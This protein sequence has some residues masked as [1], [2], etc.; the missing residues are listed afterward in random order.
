MTAAQVQLAEQ[1]ARSGRLDVRRG[2]CVLRADG[3]LQELREG[4]PWPVGGVPFLLDSPWLGWLLD[5][6]FRACDGIVAVEVGSTPDGRAFTRLTAG[7]R[8]QTWEGDIVAEAV[9]AAL[10]ARWTAMDRSRKRR[11]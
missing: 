4:E 9:A 2:Y 7:E 10:L 3:A 1:L 5:Q 6:L 8:T 11:P